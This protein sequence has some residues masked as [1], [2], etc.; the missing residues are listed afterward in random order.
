MSR[1]VVFDKTKWISLAELARIRG[2]S[3]QAISELVSSGKLDPAVQTIPGK[4]RPVIFR[5]M[6]IKIL[7]DMPS[8]KK[9]A[10]VEALDPAE[11]LA[12]EAAGDETEDDKIPSIVISNARAA[13]Y[14]A[15]LAR[16]EFEQKAAILIDAEAVK[17][18]A[19]R[20]GKTIRDRIEAIPDRVAAIVAAENDVKKVHK[21]LSTEFRG[22][23]EELA[24]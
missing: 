11:I 17:K 5:E 1:G 13:H 8:T 10:A 21:I 3:I 19:F 2:V 7:D 9:M 22:V 15:K 6:A 20:I 14:K 12:V 4:K 24:K 23:L 18:E 16:L